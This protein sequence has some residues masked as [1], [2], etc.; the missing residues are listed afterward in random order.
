[1]GPDSGRRPKSPTYNFTMGCAFRGDYIGLTYKTVPEA[2]REKK[3][4]GPT[5]LVGSH[6]SHHFFQCAARPRPEPEELALFRNLATIAQG[7]MPPSVRGSHAGS[8]FQTLGWS[9]YEYQRECKA[10]SNCRHAACHAGASG[11]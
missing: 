7:F 8:S 3:T 2:G 5:T 4:L 11:D 10:M 9:E 6:A 1:M